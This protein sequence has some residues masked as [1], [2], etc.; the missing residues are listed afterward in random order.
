MIDNIIEGSIKTVF[1]SILRFLFQLIVESILFYNGEIFLFLLTF[2]NRKPRWDY[3][4]DEPASK[5]VIFTEISI[6][7]GLAFWLL[8]AWIINSV[9]LN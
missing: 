4:A 5:F 8:V 6:W 9:V 3:Y 2:G 1:K 7:I